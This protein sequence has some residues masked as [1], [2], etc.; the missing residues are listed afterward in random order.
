MTRSLAHEVAGDKITVNCVSPGVI[1]TVR[2]ASAGKLPPGWP[3][4]SFC[5]SGSVSGVP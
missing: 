4:G 5:W 3:A 2:G 1:D